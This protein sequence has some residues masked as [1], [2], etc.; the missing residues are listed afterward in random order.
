MKIVTVISDR[1][2]AGYLLLRNSCRAQ[3]LALKP[4]VCLDSFS[5]NRMKDSLLLDYLN[6]VNEDEIILFTDGYDSIL[7]ANEDE[8]IDKYYANKTDLLFSAETN[9]YPD[10][11][12]AERCPETRTPYRYLNSGGFIGK[13]G[14]IREF[15]SDNLMASEENYAYSNQYLWTLR[16][17]QNPKYIGLDSHCTIFCTF[18]PEVGGD[19]LAEYDADNFRRYSDNMHYWFRNNFVLKNGRIFNRITRTWPCNAH[20]NGKS[21]CLIGEEITELVQLQ[22]LARK[23]AALA[24]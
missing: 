20:F 13:A 9:C 23:R 24:A 14:F 18:S 4:L 10:V 22:R 21:K 17:L 11:S 2:H 3:A 1:N 15:L 16:Y 7:L 6:D 12:L 8:I 5:G 19:P